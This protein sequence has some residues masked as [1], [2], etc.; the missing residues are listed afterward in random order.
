MIPAVP[1]LFGST[2]LE[3][4]GNQTS[5]TLIN[6]AVPSSY[7][8]N[9][10]K[11]S[12]YKMIMFIKCIN[13]KRDFKVFKQVGNYPSSTPFNLAVPFNNIRVEL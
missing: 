11:Q 5:S 12:V 2:P 8:M 4:M 3:Y 10:Q 13:K 9:N 6:L 1:S 7:C